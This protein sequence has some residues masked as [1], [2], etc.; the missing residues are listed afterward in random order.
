MS[1]KLCSLFLA[2]LMVC[3][4][5]PV[6]AEGPAVIAAVPGIDADRHARER[7]GDGRGGRIRHGGRTR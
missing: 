7:A 1:K 3:I 2:A 4:A 6:P 5:V